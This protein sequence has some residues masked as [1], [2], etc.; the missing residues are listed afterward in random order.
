MAK[1]GTGTLPKT[2]QFVSGPDEKG[3]LDGK[4]AIVTGAAQGLGKAFSKALL[5]RGAKVCLAD[6]DT[7]T[8]EKTQE[9]F[10]STFG[11][12]EVIFKKT[13]VTS[14]KQMEELFKLAKETFGGL[15][16]VVNNA[17][18][19]GEVYPLWQKVIDVNLKGTIAGT[20]LGLDAMRRDKGGN[21]GV[22]VNISSM[23]GILPNPYGPVYTASKYGIVGFSRSWAMNPDIIKNGVRINVLCPSF[24]DTNLFAD[25][26]SDN[27]LNVPALKAMIQHVGVMTSEHVAEGLLELIEDE[28]RNGAVL[29]MRKKEGRVYHV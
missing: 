23:T 24:V 20:M 28:T 21:G 22:I 3:P 2:S 15:D 25:L 27:C 14:H 12:T 5:Q 7:E 16:I 8:G 29:K 17:G 4:V 6:I 1:S 13:D 11:E 10:E 9:E 26:N 19:S 18:V